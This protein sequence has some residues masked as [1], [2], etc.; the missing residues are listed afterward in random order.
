M[1]HVNG[2]SEPY[3]IEC[4]ECIAIV[5]R[6]NLQN[7]AT[8]ASERFDVAVPEPNLGLIKSKTYQTTHGYRK[9][10]EI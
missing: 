10:S 8:Q 9:R 2:S 6:N 7:I 4:S 3:R 5:T 1:K